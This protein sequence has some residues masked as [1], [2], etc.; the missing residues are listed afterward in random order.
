MHIVLIHNKGPAQFRY[1]AQNFAEDGWKVTLIT[2]SVESRIRGMKI[3]KYAGGT[4]QEVHGPA[5]GS[6]LVLPHV[7]AGARVAEI[8]TGIARRDG[9]PDLVLGHIAWGGML[10][11]KDALPET[12]ALGYCEYYFRPAGGDAGFD[13]REPVG[14]R[15][16]QRLRLRNSTQ[17]TTLDQLDGGISPTNWQKSRYP[18]LYHPRIS[19]NHEGID[20]NRARPDDTATVA[21]PDGTVFRKGDPVVTFASRDLEPY[22]GFPQFM[23]AA[24]IIAK[25]YPSAHFI[26][27][28]G[29]G[30]SYGK[31]CNDGRTWR[32]ALMNETALA[33]DRIHF[34]GQ[35]PHSSLMR[36]FQ[37][38]AAHI[39]LTYPFVL[40]WSFLEAMSCGCAV[41]ASATAPVEEVVIDGVNGRLVDFWDPQEIA[42]ATLDILSRPDG[43]TGMRH[44]ARQTIVSR[45][46]LMNCLKRNR[47][48]IERMIGRSRLRRLS[49]PHAD[50]GAS[51][52]RQKGS[53][54]VVRT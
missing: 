29:D 36:L 41:V 49:I 13:P 1:L 16:L 27:A 24:A 25:R 3:I 30:V 42:E 23:R 26:V 12:P 47:Q 9:A 18:S 6:S 52:E 5:A 2:Q 10:F 38:S 37:V 14:L 54:R 21:L 50:A 8:L 40:S 19:V 35:V 17:L 46:E 33:P 32:E 43:F 22:R 31:A 20:T 51:M 7:S 53:M 45:F 15:E 34:L 44:T 4:A 48:L 28:G 39:Y 11:V